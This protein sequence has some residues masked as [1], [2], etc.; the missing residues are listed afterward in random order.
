M[1]TDVAI[2]KLADI[3]PYVADLA[4]IIRED[5]EL[6]KKII[7][8]KD[9]NKKTDYIRFVPYIIKKCNKE[10]YSIIS[11]I[12]EK[13]IDEIKKQDFV[14]ETI[15]QIKKLWNNEDFRSFFTLFT[16]NS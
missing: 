16:S 10:I 9:N 15:P 3:A 2:D 14:K 11:V 7:E 4:D 8:F 12:Y 5:E 13:P 1:R 6:K